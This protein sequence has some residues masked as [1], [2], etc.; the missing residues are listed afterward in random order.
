MY[1]NSG[2]TSEYCKDYGIAFENQDFLP[3]LNEM[4]KDYSKYKNKIKK[5]PYNSLKMSNEYLNLFSELLK[6]KKQ[7]I[8]KRTLLKSPFTLMLNLVFLILE[9]RNV[10]KLFNIRNLFKEF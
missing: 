10:L 2:A 4:L 6:N 8:K 9:V 5:Y 3:A 7:I 1:K